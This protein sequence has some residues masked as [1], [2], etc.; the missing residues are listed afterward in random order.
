MKSNIQISLNKIIEREDLTREEAEKVMTDIMTGQ[1][2]DAQIAGWLTALRMKGETADEIAAGI[3]VMRANVL[4][5]QCSDQSAIDIV[6]TGGDGIGTWNISTASVFA[7]AGAGVTVAKHGNRA[8][9]SKSGSADVL[10]ALGINTSCSLET[11]EAALNNIGIS[12]L[13]APLLH[14]A[15]KHAIGPRREMGVRTLFN[16]LG[17]M[18]NPAGVRRGLI[19][20]F[21]KEYCKILAEAGKKLNEAHMFFVHG[22]DGLDEVSVTGPTYVCEVKEGTLTEYEISPEQY[23]LKSWPLDDLLGGEP[24]QNAEELRAVLN[25]KKCAYRDA[26]IFNAA[27]GIYT[28][29]KFASIQEAVDAAAE[30]IDSGKAIAKLDALIAATNA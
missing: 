30:S 20:V 25:G 28:T 27:I 6:G 7:A 1:C 11:M 26:V 13:F 8:L 12:F 23:G 15:M 4:G 14:P 21:N 22:L 5:I 2:T 16:L 18:T 17:P 19:G 3:S 24:E 10:S 9:S 29:G